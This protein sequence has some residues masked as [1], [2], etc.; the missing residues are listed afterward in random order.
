MRMLTPP[1][2]LRWHSRTPALEVVAPASATRRALRALARFGPAR[3]YEAGLVAF[4]RFARWQTRL[5]QHGSLRRY[6]VTATA[7]VLVL[8]ALPL[9]LGASTGGS[10]PFDGVFDLRAHEVVLVLAT[11]A[12]G[13]A[14]ARAR[15]R[16]EA[17]LSLGVIGLSLS[18]LFLGFG[19][20]DVAMTQVA[21]EQ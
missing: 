2:L 3:A 20:P 11:A 15:A 21:G 14:G 4:V 12:A 5:L 13:I 16:L 10:L 19:A 6:V 18:I 1:P 9:V 8:A 7:V 17:V